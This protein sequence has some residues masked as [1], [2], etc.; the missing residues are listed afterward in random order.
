MYP[1]EVA[2]QAPQWVDIWI[3]AILCSVFHNAH[4]ALNV[5]IRIC[6]KWLILYR[7][8]VYILMWKNICLPGGFCLFIVI[9]FYR[10]HLIFQISILCQI[11]RYKRTLKPINFYIKYEVVTISSYVRKKTIIG[12]VNN[13]NINNIRGIFS[14]TF[15]STLI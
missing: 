9:L 15:Y 12:D 3:I 8:Y 13:K 4:Y 1:I 5:R 14:R 11:N 10:W 2:R 6:S 7:A